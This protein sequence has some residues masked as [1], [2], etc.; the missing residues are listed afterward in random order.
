MKE[1]IEMNSTQDISNAAQVNYYA[2]KIKSE[3]KTATGAWRVVA[4]LFDDASNDFGT[5]SDKFKSLLIATNCSRSKVAV[6]IDVANDKRMKMY[7]D[8][9]LNASLPGFSVMKILCL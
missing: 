4:Q 6:L 7:E 2:D 5:D 8:L 9:L 3:M 1:V